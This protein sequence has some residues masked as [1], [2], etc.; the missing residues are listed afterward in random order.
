MVT[1]DLHHWHHVSDS[2]AIDKNYAAHHAFPDRLFGTD[3][4]NPSRQL[5]EKYGVVGTCMPDGFLKQQAAPVQQLWKMV[6]KI[7]VE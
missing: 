3:I 6:T 5:P 4:E 7:K 2:V 1:A